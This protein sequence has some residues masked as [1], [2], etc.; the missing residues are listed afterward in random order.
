MAKELPFFKFE[1]GRWDSGNIQI[2]SHQD[3]GIFADLCSLYWSRLGDLPLKLAIQKVCGGNATALESLCGAGVIKVFDNHIC[4]DFLNEQLSEFENIS[5]TN[6][7]NAR[8]G[9]EKRRKDATAMRPHSDPNAIRGEERRGD[10]DKKRVSMPSASTKTLDVL[11]EEF[12]QSLVPFVSKYDKVMIREFFEYWAE[13]SRDNKKLRFQAQKFFDLSRRLATWKRNDDEKKLKF[14]GVIKETPK[15]AT[16]GIRLG[17][18]PLQ[19]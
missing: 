11:K 15:I 14:N 8:L 4:I 13:P 6:S 17:E 3:K 12:R 1:P 7:D 2:C 9:W 19:N 16:Y 10:K 5:N 18:D